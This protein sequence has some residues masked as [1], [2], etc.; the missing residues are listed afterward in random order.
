VESTSQ[1]II[2]LIENILPLLQLSD[3]ELCAYYYDFFEKI[4]AQLKKPHDIAQIAQHILKAY[5][6]MATFGDAAIWKDGEILFEEQD[7]FA[8]LRTALFL[9]CNEVRT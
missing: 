6:G 8:D 9:V 2:T 1:K 4:L 7:K 5:G 3:Y